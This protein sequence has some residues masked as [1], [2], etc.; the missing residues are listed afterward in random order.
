M[1]LRILIFVFLYAM[2]ENL[3]PLAMKP[4]VHPN[5]CFDA[6]TIRQAPK[7]LP[8]NICVWPLSM[9]HCLLRLAQDLVLLLAVMIDLC[10]LCGW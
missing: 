2:Q 10:V 6:P 4:F 1:A 8:L 9:F 7:H 5:S 3:L